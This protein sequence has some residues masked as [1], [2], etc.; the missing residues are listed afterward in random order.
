LGGD[1]PFSPSTLS[2]VLLHTVNEFHP[3]PLERRKLFFPLLHAFCYGGCC[4]FLSPDHR[5]FSCSPSPPAGGYRVF[6][7]RL[8]W[9]FPFLMAMGTITR[10]S[11]VIEAPATVPCFPFLRKDRALSGHAAEPA[12]TL[13]SSGGTCT[14]LE[15]FLLRHCA[16]FFPSTRPLAYPLPL[17]L[18]C[19]RRVLRLHFSL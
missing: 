13:L 3:L 9:C 11:P 1:E 10:F 7:S 19:S 15:D 2:A 18:P 12:D 14:F 17:F 16:S 6:F 8:A 4:P 5:D